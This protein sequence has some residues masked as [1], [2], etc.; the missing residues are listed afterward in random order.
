M[1]NLL[2]QTCTIQRETATGADAHNMPTYTWANYATGV[3][4]RLQSA[5]ARYEG[6][7]MQGAIGEFTLFLGP[8]QDITISDRVVFGSRTFEV[9]DVN[10][11]Y[12]LSGVN[13]LEVALR[14]VEIG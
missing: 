13:H 12:G 4:C 6:D 7:D 10:E 2:S 3:A 14:G 5:R 9:E 1:R 8:D 11:V